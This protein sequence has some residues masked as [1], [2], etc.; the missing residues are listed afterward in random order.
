MYASKYS[1]FKLPYAIIFSEI[2]L[3]GSLSALEKNIPIYVG[4]R[5]AS[6]H[7][8]TS[9]AVVIYMPKSGCLRVLDPAL[10]DQYTYASL[11]SNLVDAI[12]L[13]DPNLINVDADIRMGIP[14]ILEPEHQWCY[15]YTKA[16]L[17][18]QKKDWQE[19]VRLMD[20]AKS[21]GYQPADPFEWLPYIEAQA[22]TGNVNSA[23]KF[24]TEL[25]KDER[26]LRP[27]LCQVWKRVQAQVPVGSAAE[28]H[29]QDILFQFACDK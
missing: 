14:F 17:A 15:Y 7:G 21:L 13:S 24:S 29:V 3:G 18:R 2:R 4:L 26:K 27:G 5:R 8:S 9:Q 16:E 22:L 23:E 1:Q 19:I 28:S 6:F 20:A 12:P 11:S 25:L 10:G